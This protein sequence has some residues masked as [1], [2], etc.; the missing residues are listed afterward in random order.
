MTVLFLAEKLRSRSLLD[1]ADR[2]LRTLRKSKRSGKVNLSVKFHDVE[3]FPR[4]IILCLVLSCV[5]H[6]SDDTDMQVFFFSFCRRLN[7]LR[8]DQSACTFNAVHRML[9]T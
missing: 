7:E 3:R 9:S 6:T 4:F 1:A 2:G 8:L 5:I